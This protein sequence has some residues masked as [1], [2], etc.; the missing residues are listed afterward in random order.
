[1]KTI[2]QAAME[3]ISWLGSACGDCAY[4]QYQEYELR[5]N[6]DS[7]VIAKLDK[8]KENGVTDLCGWLADEMYNDIDLLRCL[9]GDNLNTYIEEEREIE[10]LQHI[11]DSG[12]HDA[13]KK[14]ARELLKW[15]LEDDR[16]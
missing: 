8:A 13:M 1:M 7:N 12:T 3:I 6:W 4:E 14:A 15:R 10:L 2:E 5:R 9:M 16:S 11:V